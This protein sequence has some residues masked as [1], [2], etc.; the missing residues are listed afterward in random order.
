MNHPT[1]RVTL[2]VPCF[3]EAARLDRGQ[4]RA[5]LDDADVSLVLVDDGSRDGTLQLLRDIARDEPRARVLPMGENRGKGEAVRAG[6]NLAL[7]DADIVGYVDADFSAPAREML[8]VVAALRAPSSPSQAIGVA[9]GSRVALLGRRIERRA[10]RH[11]LGRVFAT[12]ASAT[13]GLTVY[14]TQCGAKAFRVTPALR[15]ALAAPFTSRWVFDVELLDRL[16]REGVPE[17]AIIEVPL[18]EWRDVAGSKLHAS[19]APRAAL[20][21]A[22]IARARRRR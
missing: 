7:L 18:L 5:L 19:A 6:L 21:L 16:L 22:R 14:D 1:D 3:N 2:V 9:L 20:D 8:R 12:A 4:V 10:I 11:Y 13:L 17:D 15:R